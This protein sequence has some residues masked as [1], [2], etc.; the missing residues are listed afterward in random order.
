MPDAVRRALIVNLLTE[1]NLPYYTTEITRL[2]G[3]DHAWGGM[4]PSLDGPKRADTP[5]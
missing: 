2:F 3:V 5:S 1:D 4:E